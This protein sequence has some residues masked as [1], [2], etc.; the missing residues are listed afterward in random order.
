MYITLQNNLHT[1]CMPKL[2][3]G[4]GNFSDYTQKEAYFALL[5]AFYAA[6]GRCIDTARYYGHGVSERVI[7]EWIKSRAI[8]R[9]ELILVT[10]GGF[11]ELHDMHASRLTREQIGQDLTESLADLGL[12]YVDVY[13]LHRDNPQKPASLFI[14][15]LDELTQ[16]GRICIG[17]VSNWTGARISE[18]NQYAAQSGKNPIGVSQINF[19]LAHTTP[20]LLA[21]DTL[22]CMNPTEAAFY[23]T[24]GLPLMAYAA[25][26][27][28]YYPKLAEG[29][30]LPPKAQARY[31]SPLNRKR[32]SVLKELIAA[33]RVPPAAAA[34]AYLTS[35][36]IQ[37][38][39]VFSCSK[40]EQVTEAMQADSVCFSD[41]EIRRLEVEA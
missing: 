16:N 6:G 33:Y 31:D 3:F 17:G 40:P 23:R 18:A 8:P 24:S 29:K 32:F 4:A 38:A 26:A 35:H 7:G 28:G 2:V 39:A 21:D 37:T 27:K 11:P 5:D 36:P 22:V 10:K 1:L 30:P 41:D 19:N 20:E 15:I 9:D 13:L 12:N 34:L 14:D 25:L